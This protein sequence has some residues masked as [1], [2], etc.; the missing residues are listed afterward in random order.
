MELEYSSQGN[1]KGESPEARR[2]GS[3]E[4]FPQ[5]NTKGKPPEADFLL[6]FEH[7][8]RGHKGKTAGGGKSLKILQFP[9]RN[10]KGEPP[11]ADFLEIIDISL[12]EAQR[13]NRRR[14]ILLKC[15]HF[16]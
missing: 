15:R 3:F 12:K 16:P 7:F 6:G 2:S 8:R 1:T 4:E 14:R 9:L 13:E 10:T 11:E 5:G